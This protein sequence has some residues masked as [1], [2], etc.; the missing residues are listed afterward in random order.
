MFRQAPCPSEY[1]LNAKKVVTRKL[2][3]MNDLSGP[4]KAWFMLSENP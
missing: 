4:V 3:A 1:G 2:S